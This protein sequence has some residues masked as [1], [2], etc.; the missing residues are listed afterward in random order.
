MHVCVSDEERIA[1]SQRDD[2]SIMNDGKN[3]V[4]MAVLSRWLDYIRQQTIKKA[5]R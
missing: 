3:T 1:D 4:Y 2:V 5:S